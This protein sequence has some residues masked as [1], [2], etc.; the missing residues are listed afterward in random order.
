M[1]QVRCQKCATVLAIKQAPTSGKMKCP[2]CNAVISTT[3]ALSASAPPAF[4][5][6]PNITQSEIDFRGIPSQSIATPSGNFPVHTRHRVYDGPITLDPI[7]EPKV[8]E[9]TKGN[10]HSHGAISQPQ[11]ASNKTAGKSN[12]TRMI[13]GVVTFMIL[14]SIFGAILYWKFGPTGGSNATSPTPPSI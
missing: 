9:P 1:L 4:S 5:P 7:P 2:K 3:S 11:K 14:C 10:G 13:L 6:N 12:R 8:E